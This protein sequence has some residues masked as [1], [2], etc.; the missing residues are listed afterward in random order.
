MET[1]QKLATF[2][3]FWLN[4]CDDHIERIPIAVKNID[5][6]LSMASQMIEADNLQLF[7]L[8]DGA[9][10]EDNKYLSSLGNGTELI[11]ST[12]EQIQK[13]SIHFGLKR[14][15]S[16]KNISYPLDIDYFPWCSSKQYKFSLCFLI[17]FTYTLNKRKEFETSK[18]QK[19]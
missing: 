13:F 10:I 2:M 17:V 8:S 19:N 4:Y 14:Y 9:R 15:L 5:H 16:I 1:L 18:E 11:V 6:F 7:L 12:E 3:Y